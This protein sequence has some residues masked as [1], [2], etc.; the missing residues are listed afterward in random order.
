MEFIGCVYWGIFFENEPV[1]RGHLSRDIEDKHVTFEFKHQDYPAKF[2]K[3]LLGRYA[4]VMI[5]GYG[6][7]GVN[8]AVKVVISE[9]VSGYYFN[10]AVPHI[11][12]SVSDE[13]EPKDS[14][15]LEFDLSIPD[16]MEEL[17][18]ITGRFGYFDGEKVV[19]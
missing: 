16:K 10:D 18:T 11:T 12:M 19:I 15:K 3:E 17:P 8:E 7:D 4:K 13:G 2:P 6:N 14:G 1:L 5:I 9:D